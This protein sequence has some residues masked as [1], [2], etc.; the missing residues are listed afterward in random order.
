M[1]KKASQVRLCLIAGKSG[2]YLENMLWYFGRP[3]HLIVLIPPMPSQ[4]VNESRTDRTAG[5]QTNVRWMAA[6]MPTML[7]R[8]IL[9]R[10]VSRRPRLRRR[11]LLV[12]AGAVFSTVVVMVQLAKMV[13]FC[14]WMFFVRLSTSFGFFRNV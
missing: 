3:A 11:G 12:A 5:T 14:F 13:S 9:A 10:R 4:L 6:G 7:H 2:G 1:M 8:T